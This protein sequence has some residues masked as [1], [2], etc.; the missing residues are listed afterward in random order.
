VTD[1][2]PSRERPGIAY[3]VNALNPGGTERLVVDMS[4]AFSQEYDL[5]VIC[6]RRARCLGAGAARRRN[7][8]ALRVA[9]ARPRS[10]HAAQN[11]RRF[12]ARPA[13]GSC[14]RTSAH[15]GSTRRCRDCL[16]AHR[17]CCSRSMGASIRRW[18]IANGCSSIA[19]SSAS[20]RIASLPSRKMCARDSN[21]TRGSMH[22][23]RASSTNG[24]TP[25]APIDPVARA[26]LRAQ[27]GFTRITSSSGRWDDS[28]R[29]KESADAP[30][31]YCR[32]LRA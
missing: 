15:R 11:W 27:L 10:G 9:P 18:R 31:Q 4:R 23:T 3:V 22:E 25:R 7:S 24:V 13:L 20:S 32:R 2:I 6:P 1:S 30:A 14:M 21:A 8:R 16:I 29:I 19:S 26:N 5:H 28:N 17:S 12:F